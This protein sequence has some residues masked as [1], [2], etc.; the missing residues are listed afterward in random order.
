GAL[1]LAESR[2]AD[3][4]LVSAATLSLLAAAAEERPLVCL[5]DDAQWLDPAS[6]D[7]LRFSARRLGAEP[8]AMIFA[9]PQGEPPGLAAPGLPTLGIAPLPEAAAGELLERSAPSAA[10]AARAW[11]LAQAAG[12]PLALLEFPRGLSEAQLGGAAPLPAL[13][14]LT[15]GLE[16]AFTQRI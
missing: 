4:L 3:R 15:A 2:G 5:I 13:V 12:N 1:G 7:A 9:A 8:V 11:L 14:P 16:A 6:A 10:P